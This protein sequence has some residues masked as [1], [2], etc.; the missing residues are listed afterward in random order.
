MA[1]LDEARTA[2]AASS[3][4]HGWATQFNS[5]AQPRSSNLRPRPRD[6]VRRSG[7]DPARPKLVQ[8]RLRGLSTFSFSEVVPHHRGDCCRHRHRWSP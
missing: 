4:S 8:I 6:L 1:E 3:S 7:F 5:T 2:V